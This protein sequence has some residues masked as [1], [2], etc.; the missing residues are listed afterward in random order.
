M[1]EGITCSII[2]GSSKKKIVDLVS[3][4]KL[5]LSYTYKVNL[6]DPCFPQLG[7]MQLSCLSSITVAITMTD[8]NLQTNAWLNLIVDRKFSPLT[9]TNVPPFIGPDTGIMYSR[10]IGPAF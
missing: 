1:I 2:K 7:V 10:L 3:T 6:A 9:W 5:S 8:P 4:K